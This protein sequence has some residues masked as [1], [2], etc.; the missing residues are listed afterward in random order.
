VIP[1][2]ITAMLPAA[3]RSSLAKGGSHE[4]S[5]SWPT[6]V[7]PTCWRRRSGLAGRTF[8][9]AEGRATDLLKLISLLNE[10]LGTTSSQSTSL[11]AWATFARAWPTSPGTQVASY[12]P[13]VDFDE[14]LRRSIEYYRRQ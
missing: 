1:L 11:P 7:Q 6:S 9:V 12:E 8:N 10:L 13:A 4:I 5:S 14:G 2:F 3:R